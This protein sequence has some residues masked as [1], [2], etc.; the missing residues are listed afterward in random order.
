M[1]LSLEHVTYIYSPGSPY[2]T[3]ALSD[4]DLT[5]EDGQ[6]AALIGPT[7]SGKSTLLQVLGGLLRPASGTVR[8]DGKDIYG[9]GFSRKVMHQ[10]VGLIF[11][12][13]EYQLFE[14]TVLKDA[15]FGPKNLGLSEEEAI[16]QAKHGLEL[17]GL[18]EK[19][20]QMSPFELS[21]GEKRRAAIGGV[22]AM[23]PK[24]LVLDEPTAGLDPVGRRKLFALLKKLHE[25]QGMTILLVSHSM[26]DAAEQAGRII[27]LH[28]GAIL[29][30]GTPDEV[31]SRGQQLEEIGLALPEMTRLAADL[32]AAG[33]DLPAGITTLEEAK[34]AILRSMGMPPEA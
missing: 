23:D 6:F 19:Y 3:R 18:A 33:M 27:V 9:A 21:G 26:D 4:V 14:E 11:Q 16:L 28:E 29:L 5:I 1:S 13:P 30:D 15:A 12:Y 8:F 25:E 31:F 34:S 2:E 22:L 10:S 7:G 17:A 20:W 32:Q 24:V